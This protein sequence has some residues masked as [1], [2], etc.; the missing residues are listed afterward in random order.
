VKRSAVILAL[1]VA[2]LVIHVRVIAGDAWDDVDYHARVA[3]PRLAAAT[4][5]HAGVF[6]RWWDGSSWGVPLFAEPSHGAGDPLMWI[7]AVPHAL[8]LVLIFHIAWLAVGIGLWARRAG[9]SQLAAIG[10]GIFAITTG[11]ITSAALRGALPGIA[12]LP[13]IGWASLGLV[14]A[15]TRGTRMIY[16][17][18][19]GLLV[20]TIALAGEPAAVF[21]A[22]ALA[23]VLAG[24]RRAALWLAGA[25]AVG[26]AIG[27]A[28]WIP[29]WSLVGAGG[30][31][32]GIAL[33]RLVELV[34]PGAFGSIE[35][36]RG[37]AA[38]AGGDASAWPSLFFGAPLVALALAFRAERR[39][40]RGLVIGLGL[41][42]LIVGR[43]GWSIRWGAPEVHA[44]A[45]AIVLA[46]RAAR[47]LDGLLAGDKRA[48]RAIA[49]AAAVA[50]VATWCMVALRDPSTPAIDRALFDGGIG[51]AC[52]IGAYAAAVSKR[53][54]ARYLA[55]LLALAPGVI[56]VRSTEPTIGGSAI[57][58]EPRW[59]TDGL[60]AFRAPP[61][62]VYR[63]PMLE[64]TPEISL[65]D[66][67]ATLY[68][69]SGSRWGIDSAR[70]D[71]PA[72]M[73]E[74]TDAWAT[75]S[76]GGGQLLERLGIGLA[77]LPRSVVETRNMRELDR[78][79][80]W[81]LV[82]Y[83]SEPAAITMSDWEWVPDAAAAFKLLFPP[84]GSRGVPTDHGVLLGSGPTQDTGGIHHATTCE[85]ERWD[86][87]AIDL[88]CGAPS[89]AYAIVS[90]S[91]IT[92]WNATVDGVATPWVAADGLRRAVYVAAAGPAA[93][94]HRV[95]W[96]YRAPGLDGGL[97][98][99]AFG[100][101]ACIALL[102]LGALGFARRRG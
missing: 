91:A 43:G 86:P 18:V 81:A 69:T 37:V 77:V 90:S 67:L 57:A 2:A 54:R 58:N 5:I 13:W 27:G 45:L 71:D 53:S 88:A 62:R 73:P 46:V 9:A 56:A 40:D 24:S 36:A 49:I 48:R 10:A 51:C 11:V 12:D 29:A 26:L 22:I 14:R 28:Q 68:G 42:A 80:D 20:G 4:Q 55:V 102:G 82:Q 85:I 44:A 41:A 99:A 17:S 50:T 95:Q 31:L 101:A 3:P 60:A 75:S 64:K 8:D 47:G 87:G 1:V 70:S 65:A 16:A 59:V 93:N 33:P 34:V 84:N 97:V 25:L 7:G 35:P 98:V 92:G 100:V 61:R 66:A 32:H 23:L 63:P 6:P 79:D 78:T 39:R 83:P 74:E 72:R 89:N 19:L 38:F 15:D 21:D 76:H 52:M 94:K 96:R 30:E